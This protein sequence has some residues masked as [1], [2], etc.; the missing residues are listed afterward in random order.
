MELTPHPIEIARV[1]QSV[2]DD[3]N[4]TRATVDSDQLAVPQ[5]AGC[6]AGA[7]H[8]G[9]AVFTRN[10]RSVGGQ[11]APVG[12]DRGGACEERRPGRR[13]CPRY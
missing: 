7:N 3:L 5:A 2:A 9:D 12:N 11:R 6:V 1:V 8:R 13:G 4:G 10:K